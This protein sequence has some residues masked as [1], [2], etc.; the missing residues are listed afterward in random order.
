MRFNEINKIEPDYWD[1]PEWMIDLFHH[2]S[3][4]VIKRYFLLNE[5]ECLFFYWTRWD[6]PGTGF[7]KNPVP[8]IW[9]G[10]DQ[11]KTQ[12][13]SCLFLLKQNSFCS[14]KTISI[15]RR[16]HKNKSSRIWVEPPINSYLP[17]HG[18]DDA[19]FQKI[20]FVR[21]SRFRL[22]IKSKFEDTIL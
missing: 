1:K 17:F 4:P 15:F 10:Q 13:H 11:S 18:L 20:L 8:F 21:F 14:S 2:R 6:W 19:S 9:T 3:G 5:R 12:S 22:K 16:S 7:F